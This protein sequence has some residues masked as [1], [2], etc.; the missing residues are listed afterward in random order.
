MIDENIPVIV[1]AT[2]EELFSKTLNNSYEIK[3]RG[4]KLILFTSLNI[5]NE[6]KENFSYIIKINKTQKEFMPLQV[7]LQLQKL[8]YFTAKDRGNDPDMPRN[9]AKSVTVE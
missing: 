1:I 2:D 4:G 7:I 3:A 5:D 6:I 9:L 8:A